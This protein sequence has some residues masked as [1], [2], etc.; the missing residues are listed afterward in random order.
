LWDLKLIFLLQAVPKNF[1][2]VLEYADGGSLKKFNN[3]IK[4]LY[5]GIVHRDLVSSF[6]SHIIILLWIVIKL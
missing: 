5:E 6:I 2:L 4:K 1:S 3:I